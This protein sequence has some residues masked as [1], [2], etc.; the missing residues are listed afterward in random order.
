MPFCDREAPYGCFEEQ[1]AGGVEPGPF[2]W[3]VP[4]PEGPPSLAL[5]P[6]GPVRVAGPIEITYGGAPQRG[7]D[8]WSLC[9]CGASRC[10]PVC[11]SSHKVVGFEG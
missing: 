5:K 11:D 7:R 4:D 8:R 3:D 10:Q 9:R 6:G 2:R 1:D